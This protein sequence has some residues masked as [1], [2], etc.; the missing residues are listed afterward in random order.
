MNSTL[1]NTTTDYLEALQWRYATKQFDASRRISEGDLAS[2]Q[3]A[4]RLSASSYGLQPYTVLVISDKELREK[5]RSAC[6]NQSQITDA[7]HVFV[8]A[9]KKDFDQDLIDSY[10][11][12]VSSTR[13]LPLDSLSG[14]GDFMKSK[15]LEL[16]Q[17]SKASWSSH[18][19]YLAAG[20]L[21]SAAASLQIDTCPMEGF[22]K[23]AVDAILNLGE[24][25]LTTAL[26]VPVGYRDESDQTQFYKK[27]RRT[28]EELF[29][30]I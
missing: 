19:A 11:N 26:I 8:F 21:L 3:E 6:W 17:A 2:L 30:H 20:N 18:Q 15:L 5:L 10:L 29:L 24:K 28:P 16:P 4:I 27:V 7:S 22:E 25:G 9:G 12:L 1:E 14:Y 23:E 13:N